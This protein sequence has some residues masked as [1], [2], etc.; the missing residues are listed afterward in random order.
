MIK[1][2]KLQTIE[3]FVSQVRRLTSNQIGEVSSVL[4]KDVKISQFVPGKMLRTRL[5]A[6]LTQQ[7]NLSID[8]LTLQ[9]LC[10]ATEIVHTASLFHDDVIDNALIRRAQPT[11]WKSTCKSGAILIGDLLLCQA[12]ELL[13]DIENA[14]FLSLFL[15]KTRKVIEAEAQQELVFHDR[16]MDENTCLRLARDKTGSLFAFLA[17]VC[18][19]DDEELSLALEEVGYHIGTAYQLADDILDIVGKEDIAGKTLGT[20][21]KRG[22]CTL[23]QSMVE[24]KHIAMEHVRE[25]CDSALKELK[26]YPKAQDAVKCFLVHDF[27]PVLDRQLNVC[28]DFAV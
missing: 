18:G 4:G 10:S 15:A 19:G 16:Q 9:Q 7:D 20:D 17:S 24:G 23:P 8:L 2:L 1:N 5:A 14:R 27:M 3:H 21:S 28:M 6:W 13:Q 25:L 11:L 12:I 22:T 26:Y